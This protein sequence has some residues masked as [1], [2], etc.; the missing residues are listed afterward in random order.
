M[1]DEQKSGDR[2]EETQVDAY[3]RYK[4]LP[5]QQKITQLVTEEDLNQIIMDY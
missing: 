4:M 3:K 1:G 5:F 2:E